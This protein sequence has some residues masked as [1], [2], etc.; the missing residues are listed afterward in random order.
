MKYVAFD[1]ETT[2]LDKTKDHIIQFAAVKF[3]FN[4]IDEIQF[5]DEISLYIQP[6]GVYYI[7]PQ[8]YIKHHIN[9]KTLAGAPTLKDVVNRII[10]FFET[11]ETVSFI[12]YNGNSFDIPF[13]AEKFNKLGVDFSFSD[14]NC[15]DVFLEEKERNGISLEKTYKRYNGIDMESA[16]LSAHDALSDVKATSSV[17]VAQQKIQKYDPVLMFG[18]DNVIAMMDFRGTKQPCFNIGKYKQL[19][20]EFVKEYDIGYLEWAISDKCGFSNKTKNYIKSVLNN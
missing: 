18:D 14:Y 9:A 10:E 6:D 2:G 15:Y 4:L 17:F 16:G 20:V 11:P 19:S 3:E 8:A 5:I 12:T 13:M 7:S 1:I